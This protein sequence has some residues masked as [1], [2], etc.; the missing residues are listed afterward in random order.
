MGV[1]SKHF[2]LLS[3]KESMGK[4]TRRTV[5]D[6]A[7]D[8]AVEELTQALVQSGRR[9]QIKKKL[10]EKLDEMGWKD[11]VKMACRDVVKEKGIDKITIEDLVQ[12]ITP[13]AGQLG[14]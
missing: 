7:Q 9:E 2:R 14:I 3:N 6:K 8:Q 11:E 4:H 10:I 13:T 5:R 1:T 12:E